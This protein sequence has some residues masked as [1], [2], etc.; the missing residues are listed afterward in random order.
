MCALAV[1][2]IELLTER[3]PH[4]KLRLVAV[5][6]EPRSEQIAERPIG[7]RLPVADA[8]AL[9]P[10]GAPVRRVR[11]G[12]RTA[13][14]RDETGLPDT[15]LARHE[16]D[17]PRP[18]GDGAG[19]VSKRAELD[20]ATDE[21]TE[22]VGARRSA[23]GDAGDAQR[24]RDLDGVCLALQ[25]HAPGRAPVERR[26]DELAGGGSHE[27][28]ARLR[29]RLQSGRGV[30][31]VA[32]GSVL[33]ARPRADRSGHN[34]SRLRADSN[35]ESFDAPRL[36]HLVGEAAD[37]LDDPEAREDRTLGIVLVRYGGAEQGEQT[38]AGEI[39]H[40]P[41]EAVDR[42]DHPRHGLADH[43]LVLLWIQPFA[44]RRRADQIGE[45]GRDDAAFLPDVHRT[46]VVRRT[47]DDGL[48]AVDD[49]FGACD[50]RRGV[51]TRQE[52]RHEISSSVTPPNA[53][54]SS[55]SCHLRT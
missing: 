22:A 27:D 1:Q 15:R 29:L 40:G 49:Q 28:R 25:S 13:Y 47:S 33:D 42:G 52:Q 9:E 20:V 34:R 46:T 10:Q 23:R 32:H 53:T 51:V 14:L 24:S 12:E 30:H 4:P 54:E 36:G 21:R 18:L 55:G 3:D 7:E 5:H 39:L 41:P 50:Q 8:S 44:Q 19:R 16:D 43:E 6:P 2:P 38:V 35:G 45:Q 37:L 48:A 17:A 26:V 11:C 31:G